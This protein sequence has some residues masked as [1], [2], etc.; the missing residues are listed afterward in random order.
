MPANL[1]VH[2]DHLCHAADLLAC[3]C[4]P[5]RPAGAPRR[6]RRAGWR[7]A[8]PWTSRRAT[9]SRCPS[10]Y[11]DHFGPAAGIDF[12]RTGPAAG[13][14]FDHIGPAASIDFDRIGPAAGIYFDHMG[15]AA[16]IYFDHTGP[17]AGI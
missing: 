7:C 2:C 1:Q 9:A 5:I 6:T 10:I 15:P 13:I 17:A 11:F 12:D 14:Y 8:R 3:G 4:N 16:S